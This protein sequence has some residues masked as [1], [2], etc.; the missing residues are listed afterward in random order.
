M[1]LCPSQCILP[2][3]VE[4]LFMPL[5]VLT[6]IIWSTWYLPDFFH[7]EATIFKIHKW[8]HDKG[9]HRITDLMR[10]GL[11]LPASLS[12]CVL[13]FSQFLRFSNLLPTPWP[14][15]TLCP[16]PG[17]PALF[18][19]LA[20]NFGLSLSGPHNL[21]KVLLQ[22]FLKVSCTFSS[23]LSTLKKFFLLHLKILFYWSIVE[24]QCCVSF[25]CTAQ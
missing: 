15:L 21:N 3:G 16:L 5:L 9:T 8:C 17:L 2:G 18:G 1:T 24:I 19:W 6:F 13:P 25:R 12:P 23:H 4:W 14:L 7:C 11:C 10:S 22:L 20:P